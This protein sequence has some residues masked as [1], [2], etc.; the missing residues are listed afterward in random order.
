ML[1]ETTVSKLREMRL[2]VMANAQKDQLADPQFQNMTFGYK[3]ARYSKKYL[4]EHGPELADYRAAKAALN[5]LLDGEKLPK[6]DALKEKRRKLAARKKAL[7]A[8]YR[9]AQQEMRE[10][11]AVKANI[12]HLLGVTDGRE[13]KA[14]ER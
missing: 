5:E 6:M 10:A 8:E 11:V 12:D 13:N 2:S 1:T 4:A 3:A 14:Q 9:A 7:Y